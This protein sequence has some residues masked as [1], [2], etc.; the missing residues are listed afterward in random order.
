MHCGQ[1]SGLRGDIEEGAEAEGQVCP[2]RA[3]VRKAHISGY[4]LFV[5]AGVLYYTL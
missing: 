4:Y 5:N 3:Q 1:T 2:K